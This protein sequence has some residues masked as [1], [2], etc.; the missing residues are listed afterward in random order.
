MS[1]QHLVRLGVM[2]HIGRFDSADAVRYRRGAE[3]VLRTARGLEVGEVLA[4]PADQ[5][6]G[7]ATDG[8]ILRP[9]TDA[10]RLLASRLQRDRHQ[11][12][13]ACTDRLREIGSVATLV[14]VE[15]LFDGQALFFYFL[16]DVTPEVE[17]LTAELAELYSTT[18]KFRQFTDALV[19]GCGPN[20]GTEEA[21]GGGCG[22]SCASCVVAS[23]C[24]TKKR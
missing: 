17:R 21:E 15:H 9:M 13:A 22:T 7:E 5:T 3:V 19:N 1:V 16:G 20:C 6:G 2:G 10:D 12:F 14:D 8:V 24:G 18:V 11:A 4:P 23:A